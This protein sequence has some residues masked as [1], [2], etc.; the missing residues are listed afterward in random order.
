MRDAALSAFACFFFQDAVAVGL[1]T[2]HAEAR[3]AQQSQDDV[4]RRGDSLRHATARDPRRGA[5]DPL[6]RL[7][8]QV[9]ERYR[10]SG[11][12]AE[13]KTSRA[14]GGGLYPVIC[15]RDR[16]PLVD[17]H[18][19]RALPE[20]TTTSKDGKQTTRY[21]HT[22][23]SA[24]VFKARSHEIFPLDA[25]PIRNE[26]GTEKQDCELNA[27]KRLLPRFRR[28]HPKLPILLLGDAIYAHE[29]LL[30]EVGRLVMRYLLVV[31]P[32]SQPETFD[33]VDGSR[34]ARRLGRARVVDR[35]PAGQATLL[36]VPDLPPGAGLARTAAWATFLEVWERDKTGKVVYHNSWVTDL[37]VTAADGRG[38]LL[39]S[40]AG[41][42][43]SKTSSSTRTRTAAT[44]SST[45]SGTA[46]RR[47]RPCSTS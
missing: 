34:R 27:A 7:L 40:G 29:P 19:V 28:E 44:S 26:D 6:R 18:R 38:G 45:T 16:L 42:G 36:R 11:W 30:A 41:A 47:S 9:F 12:A 10:R 17:R 33:W 15:R 1:P 24:T 37:E 3:R 25:E 32:G 21:R 39:A 2:P 22:M 31:K 4:R 5:H 13:F 14:L 23:L 8:G 20:A 43:R 35:R 46:R